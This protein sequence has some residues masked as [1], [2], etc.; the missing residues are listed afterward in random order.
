PLALGAPRRGLA[1]TGGV[2]TVTFGQSGAVT[3]LDP[4][5]GSFASY[6][7]GYEVAYCLYDRLVDFDEGLRFVPQLAESW[8][9]APDLRSARLRLRRNVRFHDGT[10]FAAPAVK[11]NV[12][13]LVDKAPNRTNRPLWDPV[14]GVDVVDEHTVV[15]RTKQPYSQ[16]L[17]SLAHGS[18]SMVSPAALEKIGEKGIAQ[19]PVG[20]GPYRLDAFTP[21]QEVSLR[22][23]D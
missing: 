13:R 16:L 7:A 23:F 11:V 12:E 18:G 8:E 19:N 15:I 6:P 17:N 4:A 10:A 1:Q 21:G 9:L 3:A 5:Q 20:A 22:A 14:A 2:R